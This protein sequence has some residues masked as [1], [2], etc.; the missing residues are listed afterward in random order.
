MNPRDKVL[1][2][3]DLRTYFYQ[4]GGTVKAVD[5]ISYDIDRGE[6]VG[7]VG[8][9]GC[10]K[11]INSWSVMQIVPGNGKIVSG[12]ILLHR[13]REGLEGVVDIAQI[14]PESDLMCF[15]RGGEI[16][17]IFQEPMT[18]LSPVHTVG[19]QIAEA[20]LL[21]EDV[22]EAA[23][24]ERAVDL[25]DRVGI[26]RPGQ[27]VKQYP[28]EL[29]GGMRQRAMIAVALSCGPTLLIADEPTT[30]LDVTIQAQIL[31]LMRDLQQQEHMAIMFITHDLGVIAEMADRVVVMYLGKVMETGTVDQIFHN[32]LH[33]YTVGLLK[34]VP[35]RIREAKTRLESI[36]G[37]VPS[38][39]A[40]IS[41]CPFFDRCPSAIPDRCDVAFPE[42][43]VAEERHQVWCYLHKKD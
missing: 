36:T 22:S 41:G 9:S 18:A 43:T 3:T 21:H 34:S 13:Q 8:E 7:I 17:M 33:P 6:T 16:G 25:L 2:V 5:G 35:A 11:T 24:M 32:P 29:S 4:D 23:A 38:P 40:E 15:L 26:P 30:A 20:I 42:E 31:K 14:D 12:S 27:I 37:S 10:G 1:E 19:S 39:F 28:G